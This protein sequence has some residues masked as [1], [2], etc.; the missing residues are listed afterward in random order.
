MSSGMEQ[1]GVTVNQQPFTFTAVRLVCI[2]SSDCNVCSQTMMTGKLTNIYIYAR[3]IGLYSS[4][5]YVCNRTPAWNYVEPT[6][7]NI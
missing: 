7:N 1:P 2:C 4:D 3:M 6:S 5:C